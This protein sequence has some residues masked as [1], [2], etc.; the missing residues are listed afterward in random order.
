MPIEIKPFKCLLKIKITVT[1]KKKK[2]IQTLGWPESSFESFCN[3]LWKIPNKPFGQP[4]TF[5]HQSY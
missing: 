3:I 1:K 5:K 4:S 2:K